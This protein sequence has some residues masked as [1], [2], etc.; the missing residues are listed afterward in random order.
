MRS[1]SRG[2]S[3]QTACSGSLAQVLY[4]FPTGLKPRSGPRWHCVHCSSLWN[5]FSPR[6]QSI[7]KLHQSSPPGEF[8]FGTGKPFLFSFQFLTI[9]SLKC[10]A[11]RLLFLFSCHCPHTLPPGP[12]ST[13]SAYTTL[14]AYSLWVKQPAQV[15]PCLHGPAQTRWSVIS[16]LLRLCGQHSPTTSAGS[17]LFSLAQDSSY[18]SSMELSVPCP[19]SH[20]SWQI[21]SFMKAGPSFCSQSALSFQ[22]LA[23]Y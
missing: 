3:S 15:S 9:K 23:L 22:P 10:Y 5:A 21:I 8:R 17:V 2:V 6:W 1:K 11:H 19:S 13:L 16:E 20:L 12:L 14:G 4:S 18:T 7:T